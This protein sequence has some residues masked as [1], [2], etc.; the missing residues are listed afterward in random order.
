MN[1]SK[2]GVKEAHKKDFSQGKL[3]LSAELMSSAHKHV[4]ELQCSLLVL[5]PISRSAGSVTIGNLWKTK[6]LSFI[7][8]FWK[9]RHR[10]ETL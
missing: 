9:W 6:F 2:H 1:S 10:G 3:K 7:P 8:A 4:V 5:K